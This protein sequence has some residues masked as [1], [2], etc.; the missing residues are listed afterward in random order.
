MGIKEFNPYTPSRRFVTIDDK[1]DITKERPEKSLTETL[2]R[3]GGRNNNGRITSRFITGG[4]KKQYRIIDFKRDKKNVEGV[5]TAIEY[6][7]NRNCR[8]A[9]IK[10][11]DGEKRYIIAP[12]GVNVTDKIMA[13]ENAD[14]KAGNALPLRSMPDGTVV[15]NVEMIPGKGG[16]LARSAGAFAQIMG[17]EGNHVVLKMPSGELRKIRKDCYATIGQVGNLEYENIVIGKA[18][19]S[20]WLGIRPA[21]RAI[22]KNPCDHPMGGGEGKSKSG[23]HPVSPTNVKAKGFKTRNKKKQS[24]SLIITRRK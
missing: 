16:Q 4:H 13:S 20:R 14:I 6:D 18:G 17:K 1:E 23:Q 7:P 24:S 19:R 15:H 12:L 21:T 2:K 5:V 9:L 22:V 10:Y 3:T 8:I 11:K